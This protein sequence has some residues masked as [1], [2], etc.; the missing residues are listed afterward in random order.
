M[1]FFG[2]LLGA[3]APVAGFALGGPLGGAIGGAVGG[4][5]SGA[6]SQQAQQQQ[7]AQ[8]QAMSAADR[9]ARQPFQDLFRTGVDQ[10]GQLSAPDFASRLGGQTAFQGP[11]FS[12]A[13]QGQTEATQAGNLLRQGSGIVNLGTGGLQQ[14]QSTFSGAGDLFR[15]SLQ[16][17]P[18][19]QG[20][21]AGSGAFNTD[22]NQQALGQIG[23]GQLPEF[24]VSTTFD[25]SQG[26]Q[27]ANQQA[28]SQVGS[29]L[30]A[31]SISSQGQQ[32]LQNIFQQSEDARRLGARDIGRSA[33]AFG[34]VGSGVVN[35]QLGD[36]E[37]RIQRGQNQAFTQL[38]SDLATQDAADRIARSQLGLGAAG[39]QLGQDLSIGGF[40]QGLRG[41]QFG[42]ALSGANLGLQRAGALGDLGNLQFG[43]DLAL[44]QEGRG[45]RGALLDNAFRN[46]QL[47]QAA[48]EGLLGAGSGLTQAGLGFG[49]LGSRL[50]D[51]GSQ[52]GNLSQLQQ[53]LALNEIGVG[54]QER[55]FL[56]DQDQQAFLRRLQTLGAEQDALGQDRSAQLGLLSQLAGVGFGGPVGGVGAG[57]IAALGNLTDTANQDLASQQQLGALL[58][59]LLASRGGTGGVTL[60]PL[61]GSQNPAFTNPL[62]PSSGPILFR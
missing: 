42:Q 7:L 12:L 19:F 45:E 60:P 49:Q 57:D 62:F 28:L 48:G 5:I 17:L 55:Q 29:T 16:G 21:G 38:A 46:A 14:A 2:D 53:Q 26:F 13:G 50:G 41:E 3:V 37:E 11:A 6:G 39:Q 59:D 54:Q 43:Q 4:A 9:A 52:F 56:A 30:A 40:E 35:T 22:L 27:Q 25:P 33:A 32:I 1:G 23:S 20:I 8:I 61:T 10:F 58:G 15:S 44:R 47:Q 24:N 51:L 18:Q 34:R 31:P 36:L